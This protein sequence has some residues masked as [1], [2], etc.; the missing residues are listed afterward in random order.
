MGQKPVTVTNFVFKAK[1]AKQRKSETEKKKKC[2]SNGKQHRENCR[3]VHVKCNTYNKTSHI[4][5]VC[6]GH[7][8]KEKTEAKRTIVCILKKTLRSENKKVSFVI[9]MKEATYRV[10]KRF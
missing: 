7:R 5:N 2:A 3:F 9:R 10:Y 8:T 1:K 4:T 6:T